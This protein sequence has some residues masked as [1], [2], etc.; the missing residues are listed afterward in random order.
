VEPTE[1]AARDATPAVEPRRARVADARSFFQRAQPSTNVEAAVVAAYYVSEIATGDENSETITKVLLEE[2]LR[3]ARWKLPPRP[4]Q[5]LVDAHAAGYLDRHA[6][7]QY[8]INNTGHNFV[9]H[10]LDA[11]D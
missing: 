10:T 9:V 5:V 6:R 8:K 1:S 7:G 2:V 11:D 3:K 4:D